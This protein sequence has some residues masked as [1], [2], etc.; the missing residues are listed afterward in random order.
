[1]LMNRTCTANLQL[2]AYLIFAKLGTKILWMT[3]PEVGCCVFL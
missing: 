1:M 3:P 2:I